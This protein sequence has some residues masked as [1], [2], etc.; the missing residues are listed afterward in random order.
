MTVVVQTSCLIAYFYS[1]CKLVTHSD[2]LALEQIIV[3]ISNTPFFDMLCSKT[4]HKA[5]HGLFPQYF[6]DLLL[7]GKST[8]I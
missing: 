2:V 1:N 5:L 4:V 6:M 8:R 3:K 7:H